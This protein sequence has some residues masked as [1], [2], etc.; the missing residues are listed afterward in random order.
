MEVWKDGRTVVWK[1]G[2]MELSATMEWPF[3][4][5]VTESLGPW[6]VASRAQADYIFACFTK[7]VASWIIERT[8]Y[9]IW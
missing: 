4:A 5:S 8:T 1:D 3:S 7:S 2:R 6:A 9:D